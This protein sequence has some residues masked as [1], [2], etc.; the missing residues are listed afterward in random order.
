MTRSNDSDKGTVKI[1]PG[2]DASV[3]R[4]PSHLVR[5]VAGRRESEPEHVARN[6]GQARAYSSGVVTMME[7]SGTHIDALCHQACD[8]RM[9][10]DVLVDDVETSGGFTALGVETVPPL[11]GRGVLLDVAASMNVDRL[12]PAYSVSAAELE[13]ARNVRAWT[14]GLETCCSCARDTVAAGTTSRCT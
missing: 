8:L 10:G 5:Q 2:G 4:D 11:L 7:H 12:P 1:L 14:Y 13:H 6:D 3:Y 9:Y